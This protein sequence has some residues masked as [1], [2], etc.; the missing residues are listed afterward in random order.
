MAIP[1]SKPACRD[2]GRLNAPR[3]EQQYPPADIG[4]ASRKGCEIEGH[5]EFPNRID[6]AEPLIASG[7]DSNQVQAMGGRN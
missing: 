5:M 1:I 2:G 7:G 6:H 3:D 4:L